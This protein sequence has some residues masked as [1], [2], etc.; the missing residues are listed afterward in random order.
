MTTV[1]A[2]FM[3]VSREQAL[4]DNVNYRFLPQYQPEVPEDQRYAKASPCGELKLTVT[5]PA[6][7][8]EVGKHYYLDFTAVEDQAPGGE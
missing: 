4:Y 1:R 6:V 3:C 7:Q 2:K 8:F 5:N